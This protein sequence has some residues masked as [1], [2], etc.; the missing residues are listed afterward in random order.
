M[1]RLMMPVLQQY[2]RFIPNREGSGRSASSLTTNSSSDSEQA[3]T[4]PPSASVDDTVHTTDLTASLGID[5]DRRILAFSREPPPAATDAASLLAAYAKGNGPY[6]GRSGGHGG[7]SAAAASQR[8]RI[9]TAPERVLD[10][11]GLVDDYYLNLLDWST[12]NLV[13]IA[14]G[15]GV[16]IWNAETGEVGSLCSLA[17]GNGDGGGE[18]AGSNNNDDYVCS[19]KFSDDGSYLAV[20][21]STGKVQIYDVSSRSRVRTMSGHL[22]RVPT[23]SWSGAV[24]SSGARDGAI[25]NSDVR[26]AQHKVSEMKAH[27]A[28]VCGLEWRKDTAGGL[29]SG[30][31]G[32]SFPF[33]SCVCVCVKID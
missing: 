23:L 7:N 13:S 9:A 27:R 19:V 16:Y 26:V 33:L 29:A 12:E 14:L 21:T 25:W 18:P 20:G 3:T 5:L 17:D 1:K 24:L 31:Q 6:G 28:E 32:V 8:R 2:D 11:P 15:D 30:G 4:N 10:A 22:T